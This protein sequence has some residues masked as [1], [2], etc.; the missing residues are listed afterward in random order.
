VNVK[1]IFSVGDELNPAL[2]VLLSCSAQLVTFL[3]LESD[4]IAA[5]AQC[6]VALSASKNTARQA[7][8][9]GNESIGSIA[10]YITS[11]P[12]LI[13]GGGQHGGVHSGGCRLNA[14][15]MMAVYES[16]AQIFIR[17]RHE[18]YFT[19]VRNYEIKDYCVICDYL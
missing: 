1:I 18:A 11:P 17:A 2:D 10:Q 14:A 8:V 7:Y 12:A 3:P 9:V 15:G 4:L 13:T 6:L 16:M 5:A 19:H